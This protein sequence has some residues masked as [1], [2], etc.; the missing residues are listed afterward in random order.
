MSGSGALSAAMGVT[1]GDCSRRCR[2]V[3]MKEGRVSQTALKIARMMHF[4]GQ[5]P[6]YRELIPPGLVEANQAL[7]EGAPSTRVVE[8][9]DC[10]FPSN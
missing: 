5:Q 7:L 9:W 1:C 4:F 2:L 6:G 8:S 3:D 10:G